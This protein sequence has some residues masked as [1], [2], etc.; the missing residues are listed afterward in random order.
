MTLIT[1]M[2]RLFRADLHAVL[3]RIEEPQ[4]LLRQAIREMEEALSQDGR[5]AHGLKR[6]HATLAAHEAELQTA[7][8]SLEGEM[9]LCFTSGED[10]LARSLI[11]RKL[12]TERAIKAKA[13]QRKEMETELSEVQ[14]RIEEN[15]SRLDTIRQKAEALTDLT[16]DYGAEA[17]WAKPE[18]AEGDVEIAFLR[19]KQK[20]G[21]S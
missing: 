9:D 5:L 14:A 2:S 19:E 11:K 20:R 3:D 16:G 17:P 1:R 7:V 12:E 18:I 8:R 4:A 21:R 10:A 15:H 13:L 6:Q